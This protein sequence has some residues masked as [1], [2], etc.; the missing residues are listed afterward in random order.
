M[1]RELLWLIKAGR[2]AMHPDSFC[3]ENRDLAE[4]WE[5]PGCESPG[6]AAEGSQAGCTCT[7][8][9]GSVRVSA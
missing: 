5:C 1:I 7:Y 2:S 8:S 4:R 3:L 6:E 9:G